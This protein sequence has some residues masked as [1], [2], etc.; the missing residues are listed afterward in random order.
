VI[1][2]R[3]DPRYTHPWPRER[4]GIRLTSISP[5]WA[6][7]DFVLDTGASA[8]CIHPADAIQHVGLDPVMLTDPS[9]WPNAVAFGGIGGSVNYF[10]TPAEYALVHDPG[11]VT[12]L[13]GTI[14]V[15]QWTQT[16]QSL[17]SLLGWDVLA[18]FRLYCDPGAGRLEL[19]PLRTP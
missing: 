3:F 2:G 13:A 18:E 14:K 9:R 15:A 8:T 7:V 5:D 11:E 12:F 1:R 4:V 17:P 16:N 10:T 6:I 19:T